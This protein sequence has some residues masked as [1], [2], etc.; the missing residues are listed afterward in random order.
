M[1]GEDFDDLRAAEDSLFG[2]ARR[3]RAV[4][5]MLAIL[6]VSTLALVLGYLLTLSFDPYD[7]ARFLW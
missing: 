3:T 5:L 7:P 2:N 6:A 1:R 4:L